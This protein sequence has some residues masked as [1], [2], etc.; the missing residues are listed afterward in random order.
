MKEFKPTWLYIKQH[1]VT[2]LKYFGMTRSRDPIK[3][4]GSG[5]YWKL[6]LKKHGNNISTLWLQ[7]FDDQQQLILYADSFSKD[8]NITESSE[9]A[10]L[11]PETGS[12]GGGFGLPK[13]YKLPKQSIETINKRVKKLIGQK[14]DPKIGQENS[15][16]HKGKHNAKDPITGKSLGKIDTND[17]RWSTGEIVSMSKGV[18]RGP[19]S[20]EQRANTSKALKG[21]KKKAQEK[22]TC[23]YCNKE[24][25]ST[26]VQRYH[27]ENCKTK[28][29]VIL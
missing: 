20:E 7:L 26:N 17:P 25:G 6:H 15:I 29:G 4:S 12:D 27:F 3:Y 10:N 11:K 1:N 16:R 9:W 8:N 19:Q 23:P 21:K 13:G 18:K 28:I 2:G 14:R 22:L 24:G 5:Q